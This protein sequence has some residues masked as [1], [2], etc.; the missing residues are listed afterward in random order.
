MAEKIPDPPT[1]EEGKVRGE[2][3]HPVAEEREYK[4][5]VWIIVC[6]ALLSPSFLYGLDNTVVADLQ[7]PILEQFGSSAVVQVGWL[8]IAFPMGSVAVVFSL[9]KA[10]S[11][12]DNKWLWFSSL[13]VFE[14]GS[15]ICGAAPSMNVLI[16]A[17]A[18]AGVGGSGMFVG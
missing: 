13:I 14:I 1:M 15:A 9:G 4:G 5:I 7:G 16:F 2:I 11:M 3:G 6:F 18:L 10:F 12:F 8:G 17:R